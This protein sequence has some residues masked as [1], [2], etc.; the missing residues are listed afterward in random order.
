MDYFQIEVTPIIAALGI[1]GL[2]V[3]LALQ[4]SL[5][6]F[7]AGIYIVSGSPVKVGDFIEV[8]GDKISG[9]V[10]DISWRS[11]KIRTLPNT[12]VIIPNSRLSQS[13]VVNT[14]LPNKEI[15]VL[16]ECGVAYDSDLEKVEKITN[17]VAEQIQKNVSGAVKIFKPFIR[18]HTFGDSN[19]NFT[20]ILRAEEFTAGYLIKHEF[21][22]AL[23]RRF[24]QESIEISFPARNVYTHP[25]VTGKQRIR[26]K[27]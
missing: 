1:G 23:K 8:P 17:Q 5:S 16:V 4:D 26:R 21:I 22:K 6:N 7:F 20:I 10:E 24:D 18:Y 11:T 2:A 14:Y 25:S 9:Y 19:I 15:A 13:V 27:Y 3:G 12:I